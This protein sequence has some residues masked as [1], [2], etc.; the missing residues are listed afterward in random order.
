MASVAYLDTH[1][2]AWLF[3]GESRL[4]SRNARTALESHALRVSP[5]VILELEFLF[6]TKRTTV[7]GASVVED[8]RDRLG[9]T[10]CD[11]PF[12]DVV[13]MSGSARWTRDPFDR[14]IV[15][16]AAVRGAPLVTKDRLIRK[17]YAPAVW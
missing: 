17:S 5:A 1:V 2:A 13:R 9:L 12:A 7:A 11:L 6:E 8:L 16:Q 3:A 10:V 14:L 15:G 4:L